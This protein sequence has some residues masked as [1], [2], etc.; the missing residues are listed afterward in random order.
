VSQKLSLPSRDASS[1]RSQVQLNPAKLTPSPEIF[2]GRLAFLTLTTAEQLEQQ[3]E[4]ASD[5]KVSKKLHQL[6]NSYF[7]KH[8]EY[9]ALLERLGAN[10][11]E[12][13]TEF[14]QGL[15][16][17]MQRTKGSDFI[18]D[19]MHNYIVF[20]ML[21][22]SY[23][24]LAK[25]LAPARRIKVE[26]L[27]ASDELEK[28]SFEVLKSAIESD[29]KNAHRLALYGRMVVAD[30]LLEVKDSVAFEKVLT[31]LPGL[32]KTTLTRT[33]FKTLEPYTSE[34]IA[35]HTARM[36]LLGLTA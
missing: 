13:E 1:G 28:T 24:K 26:E 10:T 3:S 21:Q 29:P 11:S 23:R 19:V 18:E 5:A 17:L 9:V 6:S 8:G 7:S 20:G 36:D 30:C 22:D 25:G 27:L 12:L 31:V 2:L 16:T 4:T 15:N 33:Q 32:D 34:L 35:Q 14:G